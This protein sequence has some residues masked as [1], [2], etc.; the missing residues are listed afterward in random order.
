MSKSQWSRNMHDGQTAFFGHSHLLLD[1]TLTFTYWIWNKRGKWLSK[2][3]PHQPAQVH[4]N[5]LIVGPHNQVNRD[6]LASV[7]SP[8]SLCDTL[9]TQEA[10]NY[11]PHGQAASLHW[12]ALDLSTFQQH[13]FTVS[14]PWQQH[15]ILMKCYSLNDD[16]R[17]L[18]E[19]VCCCFFSVAHGANQYNNPLA[20]CLRETL[21]ITYSNAPDVLFCS[22]LSRLLERIKVCKINHD[23]QLLLMD[24]FIWNAAFLSHCSLV[25]EFLLW[26]LN[27]NITNKTLSDGKKD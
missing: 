18:F 23:K 12:K 7:W 6:D 5:S 16:L 9:M 24:L 3:V 25:Y 1:N 11:S 22:S 8:C 27:G 4:L 21:I 15:C 2:S 17:L 10:L 19:S 20:A 13:P 26:C 14:S